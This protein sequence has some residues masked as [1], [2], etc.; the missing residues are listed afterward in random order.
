MNDATDLLIQRRFDAVANR[1]DDGAWDEVLARAGSA[2]RGRAVLRSRASVRLALVGVVA[3]VALAVAAAALGWPGAVI[4]F[5]HAPPAPQSVAQFFDTF[6]VAAPRNMSPGATVGQAREVMTATFDADHAPTA[7][8]VEHTLYVAPRTDGG[9]CYI[10]TDY[11]GSCADPLDAP[12]STTPG[13]HGPGP[14]PFGV[15]WLEGDYPTVADGYV[16]GAAQS[17]EAR[18]ADGSSVTVPVTWVSDPIDAGFFIYV[19]PFEHETTTDALAS[20]VALDADGNVVSEQRFEATQPLDQ[21]VPQTLPDGTTESLPRRAE[22][23]Q[24][25]KP[26][27]FTTADGKHAYLWVM[28]R[29]GG[30]SCYVFGTGDGGGSGCRAP[31]FLSIEP[32]IAG[33]VFG[34]GVYF[35]QV[36][37]NVATVELRYASGDTE[38]VTPVDGF[39]LHEVNGRLVAATALSASGERLFTEKAGTG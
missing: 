20:I 19:V 36:K 10:W 1:T 25:T 31:Q 39:V 23:A 16:R 22:A 34:N 9:F 33:S 12:V 2:G 6:N 27:D 29:T 17:V 35:A 5:F 15:S 28:P 37:P 32:E 4:D 21:D 8:P 11:G 13:P 14:Q 26:F 18:F 24:A 38:D 7:N 3:V 30:G